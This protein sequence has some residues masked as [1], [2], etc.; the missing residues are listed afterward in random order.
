ML[1]Y[2]IYIELLKWQNDREQIDGYKR[3]GSGEERVNCAYKRVAQDILM[4]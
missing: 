3:I 1:N 2:F 4:M